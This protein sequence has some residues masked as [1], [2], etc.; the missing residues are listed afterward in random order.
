MDL[1]QIKSENEKKIIVVEVYDFT[2]WVE[3]WAF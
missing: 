1:A 2:R 3:A